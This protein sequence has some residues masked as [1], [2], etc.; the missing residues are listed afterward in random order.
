M[1]WTTIARDL[2][3]NR[4]INM[5]VRVMSLHQMMH[6]M[7]ARELSLSMEANLMDHVMFLH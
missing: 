7:I 4:E 6:L 1:K 3:F 2:S 5:M